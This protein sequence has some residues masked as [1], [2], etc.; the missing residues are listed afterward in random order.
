L[1][2]NSSNQEKLIGV[3]LWDCVKDVVQ[4]LETI[5]EIFTLQET[6]SNV[7]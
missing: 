3:L 2:H 4:F 7:V 1:V 6:K 5:L